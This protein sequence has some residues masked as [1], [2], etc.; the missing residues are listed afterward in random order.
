MS[1][2]APPSKQR[3]WTITNPWLNV[4]VPCCCCL[5]DPV[6]YQEHNHRMDRIACLLDRTTPL[7][8]I[9][10]KHS[11]PH[12]NFMKGRAQ[13]CFEEFEKKNQIKTGTEQEIVDTIA[14]LSYSAENIKDLE[15]TKTLS[16]CAKQLAW[17]EVIKAIL[18]LSP[19]E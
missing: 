7:R 1:D 5:K 17:E 13:R 4:I 19:H 3:S 15:P 11:P 2:G 18:T 16:L 10:N 12:D 14:R 8:E 6:V 9:Y